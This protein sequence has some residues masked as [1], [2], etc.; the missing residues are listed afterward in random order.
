VLFTA[1]GGNAPAPA[2]A[3]VATVQD[4][5]WDANASALTPASTTPPFASTTV[6][7][8]TPSGSTTETT[9]PLPTP[10]TVLTLTTA[11]AL[12]DAWNNATGV[13]V[14]FGWTSVGTLLDQPYAP[15][16]GAPL[17]LANLGA[18]PIPGWSQQPIQLQ[19][20][21]G[22]GVDA[23]ASQAQSGAGVGLA[24]F[25]S[26][27]PPLQPPFLALPNLLKV[28]CG[29]TVTNEVLGSGDATQA[30]Q[31]FKL[32]QSPVTY[33]QNGAGYA[34]TIA[35]TVNGLPWKEVASFYGQGPDANVFVT[36]EDA[37]GVD[38]AR[39]PSGA[40]NVVATYRVGAGKASPPAGQ[41]TVIAKPWPGL[42]AILNPVA[43]GG[44]ADAQPADL[45]RHFAPQ[46]V[47]T[48]G[49]AVSVFDYQAIAAEAPGV[50]RAGAVWSWDDARQRAL[51]QVF[52]GDDD[53]AVAAATAALSVAGDPNRPVSVTR[54]RAVP[55]ALTISLVFTPGMDPDA[56]AANI[57][58]AL[59]D[60]ETGLFGSW[61]LGVGQRLFAS[62]I[63]AAALGVAGAV[64]ILSLIVRTASA[65]L[66]G[67]I[68]DPGA[69]AYFTLDPAD[70]DW[71]TE[72]D[73]HG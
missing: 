68:F 21:T 65:T 40:N 60:E 48:F 27:P 22:L 17:T 28:S 4:A 10:H 7:R 42:R 50:A 70:I 11:T 34:S 45:T 23:L 26:P 47:L 30:G 29:K 35:L 12:P 1:Q 16:S 56:I 6:Y 62:Q 44:G 9:N 67:P 72:A 32:S 64:A 39:L 66:P 54:A 58:T 15:W 73:P 63:E 46:S 51:V 41:L 59:T 36:R 61:R 5:I 24:T 71:T 19:D 8:P 2:L 13:S 49:R 37:D 18:T 33:L 25:A 53:G 31:D 57:A 69:G 43:V 3:E 55:V 52:V 20:S 14:G 38:G